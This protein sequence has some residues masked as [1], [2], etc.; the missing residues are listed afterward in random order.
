MFQSAAMFYSLEYTKIEVH[1]LLATK[2]STQYARCKA[3][4]HLST[5]MLMKYLFSRQFE[6]LSVI[7]IFARF[8]EKLVANCLNY[9]QHRI[10]ILC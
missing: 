1:K 4:I 10:D 7:K 9:F 3:N 5:Q 6:M 2:Q 8:N